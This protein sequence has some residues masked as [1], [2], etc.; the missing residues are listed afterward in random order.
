[1]TSTQK[2]KEVDDAPPTPR[3]Q[4]V[5]RVYSSLES[6]LTFYIRDLRQS[7][8]ERRR[9]FLNHLFQKN[10]L[11]I[12]GVEEQT[13][14]AQASQPGSIVLSELSGRLLSDGTGFVD[15]GWELMIDR[16]NLR[17]WRRPSCKPLSGS[18]ESGRTVVSLYEYRVCGSFSDISAQ[19]F[20]EVQLN[21]AYRRHWDKSVVVLES[22][23]NGDDS[24]RTEVV[25]WVSK[26]PFPM[27]RREYVYARRWWLTTAAKDT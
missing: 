16:P 25:R 19:C 12:C 6:P 8:R 18:N 22:T 15:S 23:K 2:I 7:L 21:L 9:E 10:D 20:L 1:M 26:F 14:I 17:M 4:P 5:G 13:P 24:G 27:A 11:A 3:S